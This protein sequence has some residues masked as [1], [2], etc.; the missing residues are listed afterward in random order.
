MYLADCLV[1]V[2][3]YIHRVSMYVF[4]TF[5][6]QVDEIVILSQNLCGRTGEIQSYLRDVR[7]QIIDT[8]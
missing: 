7:S 3:G 2:S 6:S 5:E 8:E 4:I 1:A